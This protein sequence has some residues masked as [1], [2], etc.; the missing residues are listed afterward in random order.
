MTNLLDAKGLICPMPVLK[1][2]KALKKLS[3]GDILIVEAT[4]PSARKDFPA[5]CETTGYDLINV[6]ES[7]DVLT[8]EIKKT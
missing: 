7:Q 2:K 3:V 6:T 5:F 4:D 8:F 1:A